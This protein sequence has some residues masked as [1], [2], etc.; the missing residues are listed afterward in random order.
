MRRS[1]EQLLGVHSPGGF[2]RGGTVFR[3][4]QPSEARLR[5]E[6]SEAGSATSEARPSRQVPPSEA[7]LHR[8]SAERSEAARRSSGGRYYKKTQKGSTRKPRGTTYFYFKYPVFFNIRLRIMKKK[9]STVTDVHSLFFSFEPEHGTLPFDLFTFCCHFYSYLVVVKNQSLK[10]AFNNLG[11]SDSFFFLVKNDPRYRKGMRPFGVMLVTEI[12]KPDTKEKLSALFMKH[13][14][15]NAMKMGAFMFPL[16]PI[17]C[18]MPVNMIMI[19]P[20]M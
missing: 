1:G 14:W 4:L 6:R 2:A 17:F 15:I 3:G 7:R 19:R 5:A 20:S 16:L 18:H 11:L 10:M 8:G 12:V 9:A 13:I